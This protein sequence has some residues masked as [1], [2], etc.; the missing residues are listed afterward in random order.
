[1]RLKLGPSSQGEWERAKEDTQGKGRQRLWE[2]VA[3][4]VCVCV[5]LIQVSGACTYVCVCMSVSLCAQ[6]NMHFVGTYTD[7]DIHRGAGCDMKSASSRAS[8]SVPLWIH[9]SVSWNGPFTSSPACSA[10]Y[11]CM[12]W[13]RDVSAGVWAFLAALGY[14]P[15]TDRKREAEAEG[16]ALLWQIHC[17]AMVELLQQQDTLGTRRWIQICP[18]NVK[19]AVSLQKCTYCTG[20]REVKFSFLKRTACS[21]FVRM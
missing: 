17:Q 1:M 13:S 4:C 9:K 2:S 18:C 7:S 8:G 16:E 6:L 21:L 12:L 14:L 3:M 5:Y 10:I 20:K 15:V 19:Y 11:P